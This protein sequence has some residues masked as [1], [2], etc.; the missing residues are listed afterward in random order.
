MN[1]GLLLDLPHLE[2]SGAEGIGLFRTELQFIVQPGLPGVKEQTEIYTRILDEAADKPVMFRTLYIGGDKILPYQDG[3]RTPDENPAMGWRAIRVGLDRPALLRTQL[4]ALLHAAAGRHLAVMFPMVAEVSEFIVARRILDLELTRLARRNVP[5]PSK[6]E[7]GVMFEVPALIW[8]LEQLMP[9]ID[10][11]AIGSNDL[12]QFLF[13]ADRAS[14]RLSERY[15][16][17]APGFLRLLHSLVERF[18]EAGVRVSLCGEMA[19]KP[20]DAMALIGIGFRSLSVAP[21]AVGPIKLMIR[22]LDVGELSAYMENLY[23]S[24]DHSVRE[25]LKDFALDHGFVV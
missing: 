4:R 25:K 24:A 8:Q 14:P 23:D 17:L 18:N 9:L 12:A 19:G 21:S 11:V 20:L 3:S 15:D 5:A 2:D 16:V 1:A 7:V 10:F 22:R 13:A 6:L